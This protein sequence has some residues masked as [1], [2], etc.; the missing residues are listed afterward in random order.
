MRLKNENAPLIARIG[1]PL[2]VLILVIA[3]WTI[4]AAMRFYPESAFPDPLSVLKAFPEEIRSGSLSRDI[5]ASLFRVFAGF[6]LACLLGIPLGLWIGLNL[7][8]R[9]A[10]LPL[11]NFFRNISPIVWIPFA[12]LW[13]GVGD[14]SAIFLIFNSTIFPLTL[15]TAAAV[16]NI[17]EIYFRVARDYGLKGTELLTQVTIPAIMP[18]IIT[19]LRVGMGLSWLVAVAA[20]MIAGQDGLGYM[21]WD[22]RNGLR[23]DRMLVAA[24]VIG[25][26]GVLLDRLLIQLTQLRS[27][28][29][30]Y[31]Q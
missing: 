14:N 18:Q 3:L 22:A 11:V 21:V 28:R 16:A 15:A 5:I 27:V 4:T 10:L 26:I 9:L 29:W 24:I 31:G 30:G 8:A 20:E 6:L 2:V 19:A 25:I 7:R 12:V 1:L 17:T 23:T 13:F